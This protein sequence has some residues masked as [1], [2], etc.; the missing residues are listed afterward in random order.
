M[1]ARPFRRVGDS[2]GWL[3]IETYDLTTGDLLIHG[4]RIVAVSPQRVVDTYFEL[5]VTG[6]LGHH[7]ANLGIGAPPDE[8]VWDPFSYSSVTVAG[9]V[10]A[11]WYRNALVKLL[12]KEADIDSDSLKVTLHTSSYTPNLDTHDYVDDLSAELA[13][14]GGYT[15]GG[16]TLASATV[17]YTAA[18]SWGSARANS[19]AYTLGTIIRPASANGYLYRVVVAGTTAGSPPT[20]PTVLGQT[21]ADGGATLACV[22]SGIIVIDAADA[23][24][25]SASFTGVRYAVISDRSPGSAAAQPLLGLIDFGSDQAGGGGAFALIFDAQGILQLLVP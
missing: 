7:H 11:Q 25:S 16:V 17:V 12:N 6:P 15:T 24:W 18:N 21:V 5:G 23:S 4:E 1:T 14:T 9:V 3:H 2:G 8:D 10:M 13:A 19:T 20:F 22:G